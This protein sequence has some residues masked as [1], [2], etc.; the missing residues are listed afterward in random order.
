MKGKCQVPASSSPQ[1]TSVTITSP[2]LLVLITI[3]TLIVEDA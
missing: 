1:A 3:T 2:K